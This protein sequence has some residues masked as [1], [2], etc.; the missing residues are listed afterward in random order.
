MSNID[1]N[2]DI[3]DDRIIDWD[4]M[5]VE[6][7]KELRDSIKEKERKIRNK[8]DKELKNNN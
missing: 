7:I 2:V 3:I 8:I 6:Q 5:S 4:K 1:E